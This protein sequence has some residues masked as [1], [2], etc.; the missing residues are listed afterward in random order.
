[1]SVDRAFFNVSAG[2]DDLDKS[3]RPGGV[4]ALAAVACDCG[5]FVIVPWASVELYLGDNAD[6]KPLAFMT[7][8]KCPEC[9][10]KVRDFLVHSRKR[11]RS[12]GRGR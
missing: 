8:S 1:M 3:L 7:V 4:V 6:G 9:D 2:P 5:G 10:V 12:F 11:V